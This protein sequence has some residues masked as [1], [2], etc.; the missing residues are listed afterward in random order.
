MSPNLEPA[1]LTDLADKLS[2]A[3]VSFDREPSILGLRPDFVVKTPDGRK[4]I[5]EV[6]SWSATRANKERAQ[7]QAKSYKKYSNALDAFI[8]M[9]AL[10]KSLPEKKLLSPSDFIEVLVPRL[11]PRFKLKKAHAKPLKKGRPTKKPIIFAAMPFKP[12]YDDVY[13]VAMSSAC[14][15][16]GADCIRV[17]YDQFTGDIP[18]QIKMLINRSIAVISDLSEARPNVLFETGYAQALSRPIVQICCTAPDSIPFDVRNDTTI[19]YTQGQT[20]KLKDKL[21][22]RLK[23]LLKP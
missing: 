8:L 13:I 19:F 12:E 17:D 10:S 1:L 16:V 2:K 9:P 21:A 6:K 4:I 7:Q 18:S 23:A 20:H 15:S 22:K 14:D 3:G 5:V 11:R